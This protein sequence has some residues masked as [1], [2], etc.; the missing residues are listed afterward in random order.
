MKYV[1]RKFKFFHSNNRIVL[2]AISFIFSDFSKIFKFLIEFYFVSYR[3]H[4]QNN[5]TSDK[6]RNLSHSYF[7]TDQI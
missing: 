2:K 5:A 4:D 3:E 7:V 1:E 6:P